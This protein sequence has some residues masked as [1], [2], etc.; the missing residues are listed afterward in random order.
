MLINLE[1]VKFINDLNQ[2][3]EQSQYGILPFSTFND[4]E[5]RRNYLF[6]DDESPKKIDSNLISY[7]LI[8]SF[9]ID[10]LHHN[11]VSTWTSDYNGLAPIAL[12]FVVHIDKEEEAPYIA[13]KSEEDESFYIVIEGGQ[14]YCI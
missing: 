3:A 6:Y 14:W 5:E 4:W 9:Y 10:E 1:T 11:I 8:S 7:P 12:E 2:L 13:I